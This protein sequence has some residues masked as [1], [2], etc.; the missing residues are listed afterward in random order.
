MCTHDGRL[1]AED[2]LI[3]AGV[4]EDEAENRR[5]VDERRAELRPKPSRSAG[6][7]PVSVQ[8]IAAMAA[9]RFAK[10]GD[11]SKAGAAASLMSSILASPTNAESSRSTER[12]L[13]STYRVCFCDIA[14]RV[15]CVTT[16]GNLMLLLFLS[17][18][19]AA[20][21]DCGWRW[22][23]SSVGHRVWISQ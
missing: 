3:A 20:Q 4:K 11:K 8:P 2:G 12:R 19:S 17:C 21:H 9:M 18:L 7:K 10:P 5:L 16:N 22:R 14:S 1:A 23:Q 6:H 15:C 13:S